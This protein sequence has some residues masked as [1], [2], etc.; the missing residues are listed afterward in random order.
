MRIY[1]RYV[2]LTVN[3]T[4]A[5]Y[6]Q[7]YVDERYEGVVIW[8]PIISDGVHHFGY[9]FSQDGDALA[10]ALQAV[11]G[12]YSCSRLTEQE[13]IGVCYLLYNPPTE[14]SPEHTPPTPTEFIQSVVGREVSEEEALEGARQYKRFL[15]KEVVRKLFPDYND[16]I[17]DITKG[18]VLLLGYKDELTPEEQ[19]QVDTLMSGFKSVY[20]K[21]MCME[22]LQSLAQKLQDVM[23]NYYQDVE[24]LY[25]ATTKEEVKDIKLTL[26]SDGGQQ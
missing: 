9:L 20:T 25:N 6:M 24:R 8:N 1:L 16:L 17:A 18:L 2:P 14:S 21:T 7:Q 5:E 13:M 15:F 26:V 3:F 23:V 12:R 11:E 22:A 19:A 10:Q 4:G